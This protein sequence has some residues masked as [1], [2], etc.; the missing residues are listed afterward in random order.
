MELHYYDVNYPIPYPTGETSK[1]PQ[2]PLKIPAFTVNDVFFYLE[3]IYNVD[4]TF[5][6]EIKKYELRNRRGNTNYTFRMVQLYD[7]GLISS[8]K[9]HYKKF[10][11]KKY[12]KK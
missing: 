8:A 12:F 4:V 11:R 6:T 9:M 10:G 1:I 3:M 7:K 2:L 5:I